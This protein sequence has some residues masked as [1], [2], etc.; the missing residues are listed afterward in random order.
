MGTVFRPWRNTAGEKAKWITPLVLRNE[1]TFPGT[2]RGEGRAYQAARGERADTPKQGRGN[3]TYSIV[4]VGFHGLGFCVGG[5]FGQL[6]R[7]VH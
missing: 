4:I 5:L 3:G 7:R 6:L 1:R 2:L